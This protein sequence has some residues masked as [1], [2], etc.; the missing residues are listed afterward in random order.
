[1]SSFSTPS[2]GDVPFC[3]A[4]QSQRAFA[5]LII[6]QGSPTV[7]AAGLELNSVGWLDDQSMRVTVGWANE[8]KETTRP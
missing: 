4:R 8:T 5:E 1:M 2:K 7:L 6:W 3:A